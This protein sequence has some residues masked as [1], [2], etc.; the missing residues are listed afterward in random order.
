[1][2]LEVKELTEACVELDGGNCLVMELVVEFVGEC[3][4]ARGVLAADGVNVAG[5]DYAGVADEGDVVAEALDRVHIVC[6][7]YNGRSTVAEAEDFLFE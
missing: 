3:V 6:G 5:E 7:E 1:M 2:S 4:V